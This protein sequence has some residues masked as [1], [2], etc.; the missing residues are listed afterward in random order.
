MSKLGG[1]ISYY[2]QDGGDHTDEQEGKP[3]HQH[4]MGIPG[5]K[6]K[7]RFFNI[8]NNYLTWRAVMPFVPFLSKGD[9]F[10]FGGG[11]NQE[12]SNI[13]MLC[14]TDFQ[15]AEKAFSK[16]LRGTQVCGLHFFK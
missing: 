12:Q 3:P 11:S 4:P 2:Y 6:D 13:Y 5:E 1:L 10:F 7:R 15:K 16:S 8:L 9:I 14:S